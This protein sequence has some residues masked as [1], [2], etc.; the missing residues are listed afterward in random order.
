MN[1][2]CRSSLFHVLLHQNV[3]EQM[4]TD[5]ETIK[6]FSK[7]ICKDIILEIIHC[8]VSS[9]RCDTCQDWKKNR[10]CKFKIDTGNPD[11]QILTHHQG[12]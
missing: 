6:S 4:P 5:R 9:K 2:K 7:T 12:Q 3:C 1:Q 11:T 8:R 10:Q